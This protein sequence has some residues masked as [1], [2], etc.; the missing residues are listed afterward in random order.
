MGTT[1]L[2]CFASDIAFFS[3]VDEIMEKFREIW[4]VALSHGSKVLALTI[5]KA[6]IDAS[7]LPLVQKRNSLNQRIKDHKQ[8][9]LYVLRIAERSM[10]AGANVLSATC[11]TCTTLCRTTRNTQGIGTTPSISHQMDTT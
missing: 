6:A 8:E 9:G 7:N 1:S 2:T 3:D 10:L 4:S 5:P 11:L